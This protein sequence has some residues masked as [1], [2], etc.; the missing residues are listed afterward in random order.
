M[1]EVV[2]VARHVRRSEEPS[3]APLKGIRLDDLPVQMVT[4]ALANV[5][6]LDPSAIDDL[7][8]GVGKQ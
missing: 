4:A 1:P 6:A 2:I 7:M 8:L 5:P 3:S